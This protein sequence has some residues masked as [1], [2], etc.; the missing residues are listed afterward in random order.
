MNVLDLVLRLLA[1][2]C[3]IIVVSY[4]LSRTRFFREIVNQDFNAANRI[5]FML[6]YGLLSVYGTYSEVHL[7]SGAFVNLRD[8]G[9]ILAGLLG[10]PLVGLGAGLIGGIHRLWEGSFAAVPSAISTV[11]IG[12]AAGVVYNALRG[13][14][15]KPLAAVLLALAGQVFLLCLTLLLAKPFDQ[16]VASVKLEAWPMILANGLGAG[17]LT[18]LVRQFVRQRQREPSA[19]WD[20][21][22]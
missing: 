12:L 9:P 22:P 18:L 10:G 5:I 4:L 1:D 11:V 13:N 3:L 21:I 16:A 7:A 15:P 14:S 2:L 20:Q 6:V 17:F 8:L 19:F